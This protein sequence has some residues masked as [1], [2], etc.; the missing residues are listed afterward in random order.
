MGQGTEPSAPYSVEVPTI[1]KSVSFVEKDSKRFRDTNGW[2][3][4]QSLYNPATRTFKPHG[5]DSSFGKR[6]CY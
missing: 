3:Y 6:A 1:L 2:E 4:A 5:A